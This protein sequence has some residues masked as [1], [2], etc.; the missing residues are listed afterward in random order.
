MDKKPHIVI[1]S[2]VFSHHQKPLADALY[3]RTGGS[4]AFVETLGLTQELK[5]LGYQ[6]ET[7]PAYLF[8]SYAGEK[9]ICA[10][11]IRGADM[12]V[13]GGAPEHMLQE[14]LSLRKPVLRCSERPLKN[15]AEPLKYPLRYFRWHRWNPSGA[16]IYLLCASAYAAGD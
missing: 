9:E 6:E 4:F 13:F 12:V 2:N 3:A 14:R 11:M 16:P 10:E 1:V 15:G 8:R 5:T 7:A